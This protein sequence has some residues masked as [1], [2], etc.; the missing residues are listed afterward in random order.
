MSPSQFAPGLFGS[1][2]IVY[3][4]SQSQGSSKFSHTQ[5]FCP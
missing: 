1:L 5:G 4:Q 3:D 2:V